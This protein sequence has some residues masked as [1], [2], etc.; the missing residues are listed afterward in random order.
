MYTGSVPQSVT[1][2]GLVL[3][4]RNYREQDR[5]VD[6]LTPEYGRVSCLA[7]GVRKI[8]SKRGSAL[9]PGSL[10]TLHW[11]SLGETRLLTE[12]RLEESLLPNQSELTVL[13]DLSAILEIVYHI[14]LEEV[15]Q[16]TLYQATQEILRY[17][18]QNAGEYHRGYIRQALFALLA[19]QGI[20]A[21]QEARVASV[22][23]LVES[24]LGRPVHS[25][26]YLQV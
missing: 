14:S 6:V 9:Q 18:H 25:F 24:I 22:S 5:W 10:I 20:E 16:T 21:P 15:E 2:T 1:V 4:T 3:K 19:E 11:I 13:R 7:K 23:E 26:A 12:V 17:I 8:S